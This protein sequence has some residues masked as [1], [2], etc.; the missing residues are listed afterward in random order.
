MFVK[1]LKIAALVALMVILAGCGG[2][3]PAPAEPTPDSA[4]TL[5]AL[6][7]QAAQTVVAELT[8]NAPTITN[9]PEPTA[10]PAATNT[11]EPTATPAA[12]NTPAPTATNTFPP[13]P[14]ATTTPTAA[15]YSC[16]ITEMSP[17]SN[18]EIKK[19]A[20]FDMRWK[21]K[22]NGTK[23]WNADAD[24]RYSEGD[25]I[26]DSSGV[27]DLPEEIEPGETFTFVTDMKAP[28]DKGSGTFDE[29]WYIAGDGGTYCTFSM[30]IKVID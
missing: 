12:T 29:T 15:A 17:A 24:V 8:K 2:A 13:P 30:Q 26:H 4:A 20:D 3:T 27:F 11:P 21:I 6:T 9:T 5:N 7:T 10:T 28:S 16:T 19:G 22:N 23:S 1:Y 18:A 25:N 14:T